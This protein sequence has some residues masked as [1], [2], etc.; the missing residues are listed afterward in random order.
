MKNLFA[1]IPESTEDEWM[2][3]LLRAPGF[4]VERIVSRGHCSPCGFWYDQEENEWILLLQGSAGLRVEGQ[5]EIL[6][7][8]PGDSFHLDRRKKHRVE[9]TAS[10]QNTVWLAVY[11]TGSSNFE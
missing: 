10:G 11:Y 2:E 9:W 1:D 3:T 8:R 4:R 6:V 5:K 7:L